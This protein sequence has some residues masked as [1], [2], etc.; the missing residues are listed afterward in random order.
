MPIKHL[1]IRDSSY[2]STQLVASLKLIIQGQI[3]CGQ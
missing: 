3:S 2:A 1:E